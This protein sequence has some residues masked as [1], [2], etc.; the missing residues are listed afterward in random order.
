MELKEKE[1]ILSVKEL[2]FTYPRGKTEVLR[3]ISCDI[4]KGERVAIL[5]SN[6]AGKSTFF[7]LITGLTGNYK[8]SITLNNNEIREMNRYQIAQ[9]IS[10]VPQKHEP[11][12]PF[13]VKDFIMMG[14]YSKIDALGNP[15]KEDIDAV[16]RA[17]EETGAIR[18]IDRPYNELSGGEIQLAI[19]SR[20]LA[21]ETEILILDEP[22]NHLDFK[23]Q[24]TVFNLICDIS[25]KRNVTLIM[26]LHNPNDVLLFSEKAIVFNNGVVA[27]NG[28]VSEILNTKLLSEVFGVNAVCIEQNGYKAFLPHSLAKIEN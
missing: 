19:I 11:L 28:L 26:S 13:S 17:A 21:Q 15:T 12:F 23:N 1:S 16:M 3:G 7:S 5:G 4:K 24:F 18:Y 14:R 2:H 20:A 10:F 8:G 25:K 6:G 9:Y 27:A 22:N